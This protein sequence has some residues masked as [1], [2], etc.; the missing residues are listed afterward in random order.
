MSTCSQKFCEK[1]LLQKVQELA[2]SL[3][4]LRDLRGRVLEAEMR[5]L[6][7]RRKSVQPPRLKQPLIAEPRIASVER[8]IPPG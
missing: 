1:A 3:S 2:Q 8:L 7:M 6:S 4:N 5:A